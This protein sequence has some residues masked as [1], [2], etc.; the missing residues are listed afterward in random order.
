MSSFDELAAGTYSGGIR[1]RYGGGLNLI[2]N[3]REVRVSLALYAWTLEPASYDELTGYRIWQ[4]GDNNRCWQAYKAN[5]PIRFWN[6]DGHAP[7]PPQDWEL[8]RFD[9]TDAAAGKVRIWN[10]YG[11]YVHKTSD[12]FSA[13]T[14][15]ASADIFVA[16]F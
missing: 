3:G 16:E 11:R 7:G 6:Q 2:P 4:T 9:V 5:G 8:F 1:F 14:G 13:D 10:I 15:A 12:Y